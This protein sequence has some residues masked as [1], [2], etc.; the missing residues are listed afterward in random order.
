MMRLRIPNGIVR[1]DA[2][3]L[4]AD[5]IEPSRGRAGRKH[6]LVF[7]EAGRGAAAAATWTF[8]G[9]QS[10]ER[11]LANASPY[12]LGHAVFFERAIS[13]PVPP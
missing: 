2:I 8:R 12:G 5:T 6:A 1:S 10:F 4:F 13:K 3:R 11:T 9:D 7:R